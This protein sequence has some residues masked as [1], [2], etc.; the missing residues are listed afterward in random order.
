MRRFRWFLLVLLL[1]AALL[2]V[3][4]VVGTNAFLNVTLPLILNRQPERL[5][6]GWSWAWT[7]DLQHVRVWGYTLR[8]QGPMDQ[9][10]LSVDQGSLKVELR[11]LLERRFQAD[12]VEAWGVSLAYRGRFDAPPTPGRPP[13][14]PYVEGRTAEVPGF[15]N[16][17]DPRP[18]DIYPAPEAPW[19]IALD[20]ANVEGIREVWL[21]DYRF[22]GDAAVRGDLIVMPSA[23]L[24]VSDAELHVNGGD[25]LYEGVPL[26]GDLLVDGEFTLEG[27]DPTRDVGLAILGHLDTELELQARV[28]DL[29]FLDEFLGESPWVGIEGGYGELRAALDIVQGTLQPGSAVDARADDLVARVGTYAANGEGAVSIV[30]GE[31]SRGTLALVLDRFLIHRDGEPTPLVRGHGFRL[32]ASATY[33]RIDGPPDGVRAVATLPRSEV[34]NLRAF[35]QYL[36]DDIGLDIVSGRATISGTASVE[37]DGD[38]VSGGFS[39]DI[40]S[41]RLTWKSIPI[42]GAAH[43]E[44]R[45]P[46]GHLDQGRYDVRG[47]RFEVS[48]VSVGGRPPDWWAKVRFDRGRVAT[49][50]DL[51]LTADTTFSCAD[52]SPVFRVVVGDRKVPPGVEKLVTLRDLRGEADLAIGQTSVAVRHMAIN[53]AK[54]ELHLHLKQTPARLDALLFA[55]FGGLTLAMS[56]AGDEY[57]LQMVDARKWF[58]ARLAAA[59]T[60][61]LMR[62]RFGREEVVEAAKEEKRTGLKVFGKDL[63]K[64]FGKK[65]EK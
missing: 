39:L 17:P 42:V 27:V 5:R 29:A 7:W 32:D 38:R 12:Q 15:T 53:T 60:P 36:P 31:N 55:R 21:G 40:P 10:W 20:D 16:P 22:V 62:D 48:K 11:P 44:G 37:E 50:E 26:V 65:K 43:M 1:L 9:W 64:I 56:A 58:H 3:A 61:E 23:S 25:L 30:V 8:V 2:P 51:F 52:S 34:P 46:S 28:D 18:E 57:A 19:L 45:V 54:S 6:M 59:G 24:D 41:V 47:T 63:L 14:T 13:A 33:L 49:D 35:R 4:V